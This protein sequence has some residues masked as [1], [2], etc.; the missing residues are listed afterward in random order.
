MITLV[1]KTEC[2]TTEPIVRRIQSEYLEMPGLCLTPPQA[3]R[4]WGL[5]QDECTALLDYLVECRFL[6]RTRLGGFTRA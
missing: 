2:D 5:T 1:A 3:R 4:L 6:R